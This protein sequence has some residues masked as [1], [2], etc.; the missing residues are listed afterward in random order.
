PK[1]ADTPSNDAL[2]DAAATS[3][4]TH[5]ADESSL[6]L[7]RRQKHIA[8]KTKAMEISKYNQGYEMISLF[9]SVLK[10]KGRE[11]TMKDSVVAN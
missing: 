10:A 9:H 5:R 7:T 6:E 3:P 8:K 2:G 4:K 1:V 11:I